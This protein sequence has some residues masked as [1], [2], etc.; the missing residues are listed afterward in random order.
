MNKTNKKQLPQSLIC[1][2]Q[3]WFGEFGIRSIR[4]P[5]ID[6]FLYSHHLSALYCIDIVRRNSVLV[7]HGN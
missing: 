5:I 1:R 3:C 6:F 2:V 4:N 7:T